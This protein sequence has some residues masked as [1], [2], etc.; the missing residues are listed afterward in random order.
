MSRVLE[1]ICHSDT[2]CGA[3]IGLSVTV[4]RQ[5]DAVLDLRYRIAGDVDALAIGMPSVPERGHELW[6]TTCFEA[7]V[8]AEQGV[9]YCEYNLA[10]SGTWAAYQFDGYREGMRDADMPP[11]EMEMARGEHVLDLKVRLFLPEAGPVRLGL[12]A[13]IEERGGRISYWALAHPPGKPDFHDPA[14]FALEL[15]APE[16]SAA[17]AE[18]GVAPDNATGT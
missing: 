18:T 6:R 15:P 11:P 8:A 16:V 10:P 3:E 13:V 14:C 17:K 7:F 12:S 9:G 1:L 5:K 4:D 2:P